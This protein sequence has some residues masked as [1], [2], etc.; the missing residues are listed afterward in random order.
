VSDSAVRSFLV[1]CLRGFYRPRPA[2]NAWQWGEKNI[3]LREVESQDFSG[4]YTSRLCPYTRF[5]MEFATGQFSENIKFLPGWEGVEWDEFIV[6]KSSQGGW[7]L[8]VLVVIAFYVAVTKKNVLYAIDSVTEAKRI[9]KSRLQPM[10]QDCPATRAAISQDE[11]DM[12][13][14]TLFLLGLVVYMIGSFSEGAF[15]NKSVGL[16]IVDEANVHKRPMPNMPEN[17]DLARDRL[18]ASGGGKLIVIS[19]AA[20]ESDV[21]HREAETGTKHRCFVPCPH[22]EHYQELVWERIRY[23]HC[24]DLAGEYD[25]GR[26]LRETFYECELC[27]KPIEEKHKPWMLDRH[28]WRQTNPKPKLG[29]IS[30]PD[31]SDLYSPFEKAS[32]GRLAIE[33]REAQTSPIKFIRFWTSR[34]GRSWRMQSSERTAEDIKH[35]CAEYPRGTCPIE[36]VLTVVSAD[37][38]DEVRKWIKGCFARNGDLYIVDWGVT[39]SFNELEDVRLEP[40]PLNVP[41]DWTAQ[42]GMEGIEC[43]TA[44]AGIIDEGGHLGDDVRRFCLQHQGTWWPSKGRGRHQIRATV[45]EASGEVDGTKIPVYHFHDDQIKKLFYIQR[46]G[47]ASETRGFDKGKPVRA[48][49]LRIPTIYLPSLEWLEPEL[50]DELVSERLTKKRG[51]YGFVEE[52]WEK[53]PS[54]PNDWGDAGKGLLVIWHIMEPYIT[55]ALKAGES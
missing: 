4:P 10:L 25:E 6:Q 32:W 34:L 30:V 44:I 1:D 54:L 48:G 47:K 9:S 28:E 19:K 37:T 22:C 33:W 51:R 27:H 46:I 35:L 14:L 38:Q 17:V 20:T 50:I 23:D 5:V 55:E 42:K 16:A 8:A 40:V 43:V 41:M 3:W 12:S 7:T 18:K 53:D 36:P 21:T 31:I 52:R 11:D 24:K 49:A 39:N 13:N 45:F 29:K 26:M 15:A 2:E